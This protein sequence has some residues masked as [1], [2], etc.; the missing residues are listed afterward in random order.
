MTT[1]NHSK[2]IAFSIPQMK[3]E[4]NSPK[5][6]KL[7]L[8]YKSFDNFLQHCGRSEVFLSI[9]KYNLCRCELGTLIFYR[10]CTKA[11]SL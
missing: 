4:I 6:F 9:Y 8:N 11:L 5:A 3:Q 7:Y 10:Y 1:L 2:N